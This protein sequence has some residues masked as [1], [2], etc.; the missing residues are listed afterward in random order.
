[1]MFRV[2]LPRTLYPGSPGGVPPAAGYNPTE[3][4]L[5]WLH[6]VYPN[7]KDDPTTKPMECVQ[8]AGASLPFF[9][10]CI[11]LLLPLCSIE[12]NYGLG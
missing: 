8:H 11:E 6:D 9:E 3:P 5:Q 2:L 12:S 10:G 1:M 7:V 4:H